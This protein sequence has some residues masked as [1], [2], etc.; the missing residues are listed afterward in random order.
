[1]PVNIFLYD[2]FRWT[3][4]ATWNKTF[5]RK[6]SQYSS[7]IKCETFLVIS[8]ELLFPLMNATHRA[9]VTKEIRNDTNTCFVIWSRLLPH[10]LCYIPLRDRIRNE[11]FR[12]EIDRLGCP[13]ASKHGTDRQFD[14][15][16][17]FR[18]S[19]QPDGPAWI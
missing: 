17:R 7:Y 5:P 19:A 3:S 15:A 6:D 8:S 2:N 11:S 13:G 18:T 1:M 14:T 9:I 12:A 16:F 4:I 10:I